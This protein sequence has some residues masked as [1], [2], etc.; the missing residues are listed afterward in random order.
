MEHDRALAQSI[1]LCNGCASTRKGLPRQG[2]VQA[3]GAPCRG[4]MT[5]IRVSTA[6][7][8]CVHAACTGE[9][10]AGV[11]ESQDCCRDLC[12]GCTAAGQCCCLQGG[13][14]CPWLN[15]AAGWERA[16]LHAD[17]C[18]SIP[19]TL[20]ASHQKC[21]KAQGLTRSQNKHDVSQ[22]PR[23]NKQSCLTPTARWHHITTGTPVDTAG[24]KLA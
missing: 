7:S 4:K 13:E 10:M 18:S 22:L 5:N 11:K 3:I 23:H 9:G 19:A 16:A 2:H 6:G 24:L 14:A 1:A 17:F 20:Q 8:S 21:H 12:I 15:K